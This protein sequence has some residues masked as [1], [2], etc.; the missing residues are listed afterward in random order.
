[1]DKS[2]TF[3][4]VAGY[5]VVAHGRKPAA[6]EEWTEFYSALSRDTAY[7]R[8][9]LVYSAGGAL[10]VN[11]RSDLFQIHRK[12][13]FRVAVLS[14]SMLVRGAITA[15]RWLEVQAKSFKP[16]ETDAALDYLAATEPARAGL[17]RALERQ[18]AQVG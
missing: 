4:Q 3:E 11:Q 5:F 18:I 1:M 6:R 2:M 13:G 14:D 9:L 12:A 16:A 15:L 17:K 7:L 10:D 8:G